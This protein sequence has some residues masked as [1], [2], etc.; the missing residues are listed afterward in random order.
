MIKLLL[1]NFVNEL[2]P[3]VKN[4]LEIILNSAYH[5]Q[6][7]IEDA[8]DMSRL[9]N[10]KFQI[11]NELFD[12]RKAVE[13][14]CNIMR[15]QLTSKDLDLRIVIQPSVPKKILAD[16]KCF[17]QILFNLMGNAVKFTFTGSLIVKLDFVD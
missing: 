1:D 15:F 5:L 9:E 17:K 4:Y 13:D 2:N 11:F 12:V 8:L 16:A 6:N 14:V 10:N 3:R 7:V